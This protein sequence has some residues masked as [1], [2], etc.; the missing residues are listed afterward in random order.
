MLQSGR[1]ILHDPEI[2]AAVATSALLPKA[3]TLSLIYPLKD[4]SDE[5]TLNFMKNESRQVVVATGK[6]LIEF[7]P[8]LIG[9]HQKMEIRMKRSAKDI[10]RLATCPT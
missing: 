2:V 5:N 10:R 4:A 8:V 6:E 3:T 1:P 9:S 7:Y